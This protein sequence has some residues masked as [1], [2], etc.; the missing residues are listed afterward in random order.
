METQLIQRHAKKD[1]FA[2]MVQNLAPNT[3]AHLAHTTT[4][5]VMSYFYTLNL[6]DKCFYRQYLAVQSCKTEN[7]KF[8]EAYSQKTS[9]CCKVATT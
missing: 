2:S 4:K 9:R 7:T 6:L 3:R 8:K 5:Q 1:I